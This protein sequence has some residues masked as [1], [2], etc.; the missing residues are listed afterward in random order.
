METSFNSNPSA[1]AQ[2][3]LQ[4][5]IAIVTGAGCVGPGWGNGRAVTVL[6]AQAG[7][8]IFAVD[9]NMEAMDETVRRVREAGG[10]V[11]A[12]TCD[13]TDT[14]AVEAMVA[15]CTAEYGRVD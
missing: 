4:G 11:T 10:K 15:A 14:A 3:R 2:G 6:F 13:V 9:K 12:Y 8:T 5:K 7:A 1:T